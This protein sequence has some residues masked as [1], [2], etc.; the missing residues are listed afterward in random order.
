MTDKRLAA[1]VEHRARLMLYRA[2]TVEQR[3]ALLRWLD[4]AGVYK[5]RHPDAQF[6]EVRAAVRA[7]R[8]SPLTEGAELDRICG[9]VRRQHHPE[10]AD[11]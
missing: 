6:E 10:E 7:L 5:K 11:R 8:D 9:E 4:R 3:G 1:S 2:L